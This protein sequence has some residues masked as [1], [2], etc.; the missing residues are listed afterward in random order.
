M[1]IGDPLSSKSN[2]GFGL[3]PALVLAPFLVVISPAPF[4]LRLKSLAFSGAA[5]SRTGGC[6]TVKPRQAIQNRNSS[7]AFSDDRAFKK[8]ATR[9]GGSFGLL[10]L[11]LTV[12]ST[13][14]SSL[15]AVTVAVG[16]I[17]SSMHIVTCAQSRL[18][19]QFSGR[20]LPTRVRSRVGRLTSKP[21]GQFWS[22][23]S[24]PGQRSSGC[25]TY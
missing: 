20:S 5:R 6:P 25:H 24:T 1:R 14:L 22:R 17:E 7:K 12:I 11:Q 3:D 15:H 10:W 16:R 4:Q 19:P 23:A 2:F 21:R 18:F 13:D 9:S 8:R